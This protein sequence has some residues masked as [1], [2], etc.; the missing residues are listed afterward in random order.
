MIQSVSAGFQ[1]IIDKNNCIS[2]FLHPL[3]F[4]PSLLLLFHLLTMSDKIFACNSCKKENFTSRSDRDKHTQHCVKFVDLQFP[5]GLVKLLR[6][7][8][9]FRCCCSS[10]TCP[11]DFR[12]SKTIKQHIKNSKSTWI[13]DKV[14]LASGKEFFD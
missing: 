8:G 6:Q 7:N 10:A 3:Y 14:I 1:F 2:Y 12:S 13:G 5:E 11:Q 4:P 9:V